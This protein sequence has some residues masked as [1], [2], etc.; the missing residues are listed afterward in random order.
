MK[1]DIKLKLIKRATTSVALFF[2]VGLSSGVYAEKLETYKDIIEKSYNL[3]IQKNRTQAMNLLVSSIR[4]EGKKSQAVKELMSALDEVSTAFYS[5][6]AQQQYELALSVKATDPQLAL[7]HLGEAAKMEPDNLTILLEQMKMQMGSGDCS[8]ALNQAQKLR[9]QNPY[10]DAIALALA[11]AAVCSGQLDTY[12]QTRN[13]SD[14]KKSNYL[15]YWQ[16]VEIEYLYKTAAFAKAKELAQ[17]VLRSETK[18][19]EP[20]YWIW[21]IEAEQKI[22]AEK[23]A[24]KYTLMC[25][26][27]TTREQRNFGQ[28]PMLCRRVSEV[29]SYLKKN[30]SAD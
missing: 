14:T 25:K 5:E 1:F 2:S 17:Q 21:K 26:V 23:S 11:Q 4:R 28:D 7:N 20:Q 12:V 3:S 27:M 19:P 22:K 30:N 24:Q 6:K 13:L 18:Y 16:S 10:S 29:E 9:E 8:A 15:S